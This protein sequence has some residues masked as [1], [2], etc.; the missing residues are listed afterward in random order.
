M[1]VSI[2]V[3]GEN[4]VGTDQGDLVRRLFYKLKQNFLI[5]SV[6]VCV[7]RTMIDED[8]TLIKISVKFF[9]FGSLYINFIPSLCI[10]KV[11]G[12]KKCQK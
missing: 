12:F 7:F 1:L 11:N 3:G 6:S 9:G 5:Y 2:R 4:N 10:M 8:V